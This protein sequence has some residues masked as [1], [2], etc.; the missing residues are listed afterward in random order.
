MEKVKAVYYFFLPQYR[1][2]CSR[3]LLFVK[4]YYKMTT[5]HLFSLSNIT[6]I[7]FL[8]TGTCHIVN[9][10]LIVTLGRFY[11]KNYYIFTEPKYTIISYNTLLITHKYLV[12]QMPG[13]K[14]IL[15]F[16]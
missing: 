9:M 15:N 3:Q 4:F 11:F 8:Q 7:V 12:G 16:F 6:K 2:S 13:E 5:F 10:Q 14:V 1:K